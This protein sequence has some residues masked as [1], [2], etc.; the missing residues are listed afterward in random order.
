MLVMSSITEPGVSHGALPFAGREEELATLLQA[1]RNSYNGARTVT[2]IDGEMGTGKS[3]LLDEF[4]RTVEVA[5]QFVV[6]LRL[7]RGDVAESF[8]L[9]MRA[10]IDALDARPQLRRNIESTFSLFIES[11]GASF[12]LGRILD[13]LVRRV[14]VVIVIDDFDAGGSQFSSE[15]GALMRLVKGPFMIAA[16]ASP[17][18]EDRLRNTARHAEADFSSIKLGTLSRETIANYIELLFGI[19]IGREDVTWLLDATHGLPILLREAT[20]A[21]LRSGC[22]AMHDRHWRRLHPFKNCHFSAIDLLPTLSAQLAEL[23][24]P[25]RALLGSIALLGRRVPCDVLA[26]LGFSNGWHTTFVDRGILMITGE[27]VVFV[28]QLVFEVTLVDA[29][30]SQRYIGMHERIIELLRRNLGSEEPLAIPSK[31]LRMLLDS[32]NREERAPLLDAILEAAERMRGSYRYMIAIGYF[33]EC[34]RWWIELRDRHTVVTLARWTAAHADTLYKLGRVPEQ[35]KILQEFLA[36]F[37]TIPPSKE[38]APL[39]ARGLLRI[40]EMYSREK[41]LDDAMALLERSETI[42]ILCDAKEQLELRDEI[43]NHRAEALRA[44]DRNA[45]AFAILNQLLDRHD[46]NIFSP[47]AFDALIFLAR[48]T[49]DDEEWEGVMKRVHEM[50]DLCEREGLTRPALQLRCCILQD[51]WAKQDM[52]AFTAM[53]RS[54]LQELQEAPLPRTESNIWYWFAIDASRQGDY[55]EAVA[56]IDKAIDIRWNVKSIAMWQYA[57]VIKGVILVCAGRNE[58]ALTLFQHV[59][60][61]AAQ[62]G[63]NVHR[64]LIAAYRAII[65]ARRG[66]WTEGDR[67]VARIAELGVAEEYHNVDWVIT[68]LQ[69]EILLNTP[70]PSLT[71]AESFAEA[72]SK[73]DLDD[74]D[75]QFLIVMAASV[76]GRAVGSSRSG[77]RQRRRNK[78]I[79]ETTYRTLEVLRRW[80]QRRAHYNIAAYIRQLRTY[81]AHLFDEGELDPFVMEHEMPATLLLEI[82][83]LEVLSFGRLRVVDRSGSERE[84]RHF[85]TQKSDSKPR[86]VLAALVVAGVQGRRLARERLIDMVWGESTSDESAA[87]N[88]HVTLSG[89]RQV[90]GDGID[91]DGRS[92]A[93]N[94]QLLRVDV[95]EFHKLLDEARRADHAAMGYRAYDLLKRAC[96]LYTGEFL[97]GIYDEWSDGPREDLRVGVRAAY[98]RLTELAISRG[99]HNVARTSIQALFDIDQTDEEAMLLSLWILHAE[100]ER[101]R[102]IREYDE[103]AR[104]LREEYGVDPSKRLREFRDAIAEE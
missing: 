82:T 45:E 7:H 67:G 58:E 80:Q 90:M 56:N 33:N 13:A 35:M 53:A 27:A 99:E 64:F 88:F 10:L 8:D 46:P 79:I 62:N 59:E 57:M 26:L 39:V 70:E 104:L 84:G 75:D 92:Y 94:L 72:A 1:Y 60:E 54:L 63:R 73:L 9:L 51:L 40:V 87:N 74:P 85:G 11:D 29:E 25:D 34:R 6:R 12:R 47:R 100:G 81:A 52:G 96:G 102:A 103:F 55:V 16:T 20:Y 19:E 31:T 98:L 66:E 30:R 43:D 86:K 14:P 44:A 24:T 95:V 3:R 101:P 50:L 49:H 65:A 4:C 77:G 78:S 28:H 15:L 91:F 68:R 36:D 48:T 76:M 71:R 2:M 32:S 22:I 97:E 37:D 17:G 38:L 89:L 42:A 41:K 18:G 23:P 93:L 69:G 83:E 61:D 5:P 21:L